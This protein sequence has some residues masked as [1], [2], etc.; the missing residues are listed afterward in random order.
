[1]QQGSRNE[2]EEE[3]EERNQPGFANLIKMFEL[4]NA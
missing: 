1:M 3:E 2:E 4:D